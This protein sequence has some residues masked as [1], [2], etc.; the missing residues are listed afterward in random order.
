MHNIAT[1]RPKN[2][3]PTVKHYSMK[4]NMGN[5]GVMPHTLS[6]GTTRMEVSILPLQPLLL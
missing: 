5:D 1:F 6:L 3:P 2:I 4:V